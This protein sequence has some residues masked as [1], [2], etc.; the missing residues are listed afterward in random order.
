MNQLE[1]LLTGLDAE[2]RWLLRTFLMPYSEWIRLISLSI[3]PVTLISACGLLCLAFYSRLAAIVSRLRGFQRERLLA[4]DLASRA[5]SQTSQESN[6]RQRFMEHLE[7]QTAQVTRRAQLI[8]LTL[9]FLLLAIAL[10]VSCCLMLGLSILSPGCVFLAVAL[11]I[12]GVLSML[13]ATISALVEL[14]EA[15][16]PAELESQ[17]VTGILHEQNR[18]AGDPR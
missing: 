18:R 2:R 11:F 9:I 4:Q 8:R 16:Q 1:P 7:A 5:D 17:F 6:R 12:F 10:L 13:A 14:R 3:A 15:L